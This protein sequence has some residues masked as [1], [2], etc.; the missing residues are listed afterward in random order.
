MDLCLVFEN[1]NNL[2]K[3][4]QIKM[5]PGHQSIYASDH[6]HKLYE[7]GWDPLDYMNII[8]AS[9]LN[10]SG[11]KI[12]DLG[13]N[14]GGLSLELAREGAS[15]TISD[16]GEPLQKTKSIIYDAAREEG[17]SVFIE[18]DGLYECAERYLPFTFDIVVCFGLLYH[19]RNPH[20]VIDKLNLIS[21]TLLIGTHTY[22]G[23]ELKLVNRLNPG[24]IARKNFFSDDQIFSGY[25]ISK[26]MIERM[27]MSS[28][29][30]NIQ[31]ISDPKIDFPKKAFPGVGN[32]GYWICERSILL[33]GNENTIYF[34][35]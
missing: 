27:L 6:S 28:G 22:P 4:E 7:G 8:K 14:T 21:P 31:L 3:M 25:H 32:S 16:P 10:L 12:L 29:F 30:T 5:N 11:K 34:P 23:N 9:G 2:I 20:D 15:V 19:F 26:P 18:V 24:M 33:N 17:L 1:N 13:G 35:R